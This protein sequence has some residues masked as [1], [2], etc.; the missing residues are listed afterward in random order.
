M[1]SHQLVTP[2]AP[3]LH[4]VER[5]GAGPTLVLIHGFTD[6]WSSWTPV[7]DALPEALPIVAYDLRGHGQSAHTPG[8]Y[9]L[10]NHIHD[11]VAV[12]EQFVSGP[13][14]LCG[15]SLGGLVAAGLAAE[16]PGRV[17]GLILEDV[18]FPDGA[19][20]AEFA[21]WR[22][23]LA[24]LQGQPQ[25][26]WAQQ[27]GQWP[28]DEERTRE[29]TFGAEGVWRQVGHWMQLDLAHMDAV[30]DGSHW[31][32]PR[33]DEATTLAAVRCPALLIYQPERADMAQR[34][35]TRLGQS[36]VQISS[37]ANHRIHELAPGWFAEQVAAFLDRR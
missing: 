32:D 31:G 21:A 16:E 35:A 19:I 29:A 25:E 11:A 28:F 17:A 36:R 22:G 33:P 30:I 7:I 6:S 13:A 15:H 1:R 5:P 4:V 3:G 14:L 34:M 26:L 24:A 27:V 8:A 9:T 37:V 23:R 20:G 12:L 10:Q 2:G 18:A